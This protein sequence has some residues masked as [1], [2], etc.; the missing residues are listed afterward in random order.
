M[1]LRNR[2][3]YYFVSRLIWLLLVW[4]LLIAGSMLLFSFFFGY[5]KTPASQWSVREIAEQTA[6]EGSRLT[7]APD[8]RE[9]I[10]RNDMWL[11]VLNEQG[12]EIY[13]VNKPESITDHYIPGKLVSDYI[14]PAKNGY[15]LSTW[16]GAAGGRELTWVVG[17]PSADGNPLLYGLNILWIL[18]I[19]AVGIVT[20]LYFG[21]Q[22]GSPLL[23]IVSWIERL[24]AGKYEE[25]L[26]QRKSVLN[27]HLR[28]RAEYRTFHELIQA[29]SRLTSALRSNKE[30]RELL[31]KTRE[32]W[33]AGVS[34]DLKTPLSV[35][36]GYTVLLSS[37]EYDWEPDQVRGFSRIMGDRV[38]Y[39]ERLI[40][41]FGLTFRLKNDALPLRLEPNDLVRMTRDI[42]KQLQSLPE[43]ADK[44][45]LF[46]TNRGRI[47]LDLDPG[48]MQRA[49]ENVIANSIKH[50]PPGTTVKITINEERGTGGRVRIGIE[51]NGA[52]MDQETLARLFER[53]FRGTN[54]SSDSS[55]TGLGMAIARQIILAHGG[56]ID[57]NSRLG[58][59]TVCMITFPH[60]RRR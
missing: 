55:G 48:Y 22:L 25:P 36:K 38:E 58:Q 57:I 14:Y 24:S 20:V 5:G 59:G 49:L 16:Y 10:I 56:E 45:F 43:S 9:D 17:R 46:E 28:K 21:R 44:T 11:Q 54:A 37:S 8:V 12:D 3:A 29:L 34:H 7:V 23:Y 32:E 15:Q 1:K 60:P 18:A 4:G 40:E 33:M 31:E 30:E 2:I 19:L 52:G 6:V 42:L 53:Y 27:G 41:D 51:D 13:S 35:I 39:M 47:P 50:N 26:Q